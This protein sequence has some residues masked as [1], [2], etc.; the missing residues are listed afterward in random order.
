MHYISGKERRK[1]LRSH[2][3]VEV[4]RRVWVISGMPSLSVNNTE[5]DLCW[6]HSESG[7]TWIQLGS[8][9]LTRPGGAYFPFP[10]VILL[11]VAMRTPVSNYDETDSQAVTSSNI[12][13]RKWTRFI[14]R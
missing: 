1:N 10:V 7:D 11:R 14:L 13:L 3:P 12:S 6:Y 9:A 2:F 4:R 5:T 8:A